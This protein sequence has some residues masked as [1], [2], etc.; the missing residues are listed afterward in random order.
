MPRK[1]ITDVTVADL[2]E[3]LKKKQLMQLLEAMEEAWVG[4]ILSR[5]HS[6]RCG[7]VYAEDKHVGDAHT[8]TITLELRFPI[9][10]SQFPDE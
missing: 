1:V 5:V 9:E 10:L 3:P 4:G 6:V 7:T 8:T 2:C